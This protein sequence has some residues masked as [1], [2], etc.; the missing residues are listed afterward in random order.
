MGYYERNTLSTDYEG[1]CGN[2]H[3]MLS[4]K[5]K[6]CRYCGT[7]VGEGKFQPYKNETYCVYGPPVKELWH[8]PDCGYAW[9]ST[10][11]GGDN[12]K[13][14]PIAVNIFLKMLLMDGKILPMKS[15]NLYYI[16]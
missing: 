10:V 11:M 2:C 5:D 3:S 13:Y 15:L 8:C 12:P 9:R 1:R 4:A 14:C 16:D 7:P 6:Y